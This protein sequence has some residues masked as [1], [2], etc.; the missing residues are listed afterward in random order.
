MPRPTPA[1]ERAVDAFNITASVNP[2]IIVTS[3]NIRLSTIFRTA[4][5]DPNRIYVNGLTLG[6]SIEFRETEIDE[7]ISVLMRY[8]AN[9]VDNAVQTLAAPTDDAD[10]EI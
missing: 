3:R 5:G 1:V 2:N 7:L 9:M 8:R 4:P 10:L 6:G